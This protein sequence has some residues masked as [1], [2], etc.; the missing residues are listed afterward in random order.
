VLWNNRAGAE[1]I[2]RGERNAASS[3]PEKGLRRRFHFRI[4]VQNDFLASR[5]RLLNRC[6]LH[7]FP[8]ANRTVAILQ[9]HD[10]IPALLFELNKRQTVVSKMS[11]HDVFQPL[12]VNAMEI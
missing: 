3:E 11:H 6:N 4:E 1:C 10:Q 7:Q 12:G 5:D 9:R 2:D 8:T